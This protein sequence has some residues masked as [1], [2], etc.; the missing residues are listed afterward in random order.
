MKKNQNSN[1]Q[2]IFCLLVVIVILDFHSV[3][4]DGLPSQ[5]AINA[6]SVFMA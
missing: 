4:S 1:T 3:K 6:E 5:K 2:Y